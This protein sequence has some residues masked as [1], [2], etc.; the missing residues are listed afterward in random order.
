LGLALLPLMLDQLQMAMELDLDLIDLNPEFGLEEVCMEIQ[1]TIVLVLQEIHHR[2]FR[3]LPGP[4]QAV[5]HFLD[6]RGINTFT[7]VQ[8]WEYFG[9]RQEHLWWLVEAFRLPHGP[10]YTD[11]RCRFTAD[12]VLLIG[13][14]RLRTSGACDRTVCELFHRE[15][16]QI[17]RAWNLF[18]LYVKEHNEFLLIDNLEYWLPRFPEFSQ[19]IRRKLYEQAGV[20]VPAHE[21]HVAAFHDTTTVPTC[22]PGSGP[23]S[24][25]NR[26]DPRVPRSAY[27]RRVHGLKFQTM[28]LP[29][30]MCGHLFGPEVV[31]RNDREIVARSHLNDR[32]AQLQVGQPFQ[33][34][35]F[36]DAIYIEDTHIDTFVKDPDT[37]FE[38]AYNGGMRRVRVS[39]E[40]AYQ[41]TDQI[42]PF[43]TD[44]RSFKLLHNMNLR[45]VYVVAT[46]VRNAGT[47]L[48]GN[49]ISSYFR[50]DPPR[51]F[52]YF[53]I[54]HV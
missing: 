6:P 7:P 8:C 35:S 1:H 14:F 19:C 5:R 3:V 37:E 48:Y 54:E 50:C 16:S 53:Q 34:H 25:G 27:C 45:Y 47:C 11:N 42:N 12:E 31:R 51:L 15:F 52:E 49:V 26:K 9:F 40:Q 2:A 30:G 17:S 23:D 33:Y 18:I 22:R 46:L 28:E 4:V 32:L 43:I 41:V 44:K 13:L 36:G 21:F 29:N 39:N 20:Y 38:K 10:V 24:Q